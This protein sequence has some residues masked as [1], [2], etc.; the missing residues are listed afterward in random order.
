MLIFLSLNI[1]V[2]QIQTDLEQRTKELLTAKTE[3]DDLKERGRAR[4]EEEILKSQKLETELNAAE[5]RLNGKEGQTND[6]TKELSLLQT[7]CK[8]QLK[9]SDDLKGQLS[10]KVNELEDALRHNKNKY[11]NKC[12]KSNK[13]REHGENIISKQ[14]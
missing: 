8:D 11:V 7:R 3:L 14:M 4:L 1:D 13:I 12:I 10:E 9:L 5:N 6:L 2:L